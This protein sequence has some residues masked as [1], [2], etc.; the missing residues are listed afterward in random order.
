[1]FWFLCFNRYVILMWDEGADFPSFD[2]T[3]LF[4]YTF[5]L[6][7]TLIFTSLPVG[8]MGAFEQDTNAAASMAF[9]ALYMRGVRGLDYT[10]RRF[11]TYMADGLYQSAILFFIPFLAY[12]TAAPWSASGRGTEGLYDLGTTIACAGVISANLYVGINTQ[13]WTW[14]AVVVYTFSTLAI[15]IWIPVYS[16]LAGLPFNGEVAILFSTFSFWAVTLITVFCAVGPKWIVSAFRQSYFPRDKDIVREAWIAGDL[17][18]QLGIKHRRERRKPQPVP[19]FEY[20]QPS[21][22]VDHLHKA[23][24]SD[25]LRDERGYYEPAAMASP[26][27]DIARSPLYSGASSPRSPFTYP[28]T[29]PAI[30]GLSGS[31]YPA[32]P[33]GQATIPPPLLL[34]HSSGP[35]KLSPSPSRSQLAVQSGDMRSPGSPMSYTSPTALDA[36]SKASA[37]IKRLSRASVD[38]QSASL[39]PERAQRGTGVERTGSVNL[40][41]GDRRRQSGILVQKRNSLPGESMLGVPNLPPVRGSF[42]VSEEHDRTFTLGHEDDNERGN[43]TMDF[44]DASGADWEGSRRNTMIDLNDDDDEEH[45]TRGYRSRPESAGFAV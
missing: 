33:R 13:Y 26:Q 25:Q 27:K 44:S 14:M 10:R 12:G 1:M 42:D 29:S 21:S 11:W 28:P 22:L 5:L 36:F 3:Y 35:T 18:D 39:S 20:D 8:V 40:G 37:E 19:T 32:R 6:L 23:L 2:A 24:G 45:D 43:M 31:A 7:Y 38:L 4:E 30:D 16:Y 15:Y 41:H 17:K 34:R 9:P